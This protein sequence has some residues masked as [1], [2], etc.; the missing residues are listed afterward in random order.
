MEVYIDDVVMKSTDFQNHLANLGQA[1]LRMRKHYLKMNLAKCAFRVSAGNFLRFLVHQ[2]DMDK[3]KVKT[4]L[5]V[6]P[7]VNEKEL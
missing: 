2:K 6:R 1:F 3:N 5:E 7:L 4:M